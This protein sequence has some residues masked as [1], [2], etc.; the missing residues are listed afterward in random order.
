MERPEN[1]RVVILIDS[2]NYEEML[3]IDQPNVTL[4]NA[5]VNPNIDLIENGVQIADGAVRITSYYGHGYH[6]FSM[7]SNQKWN[8][9]V[10]N[11]NLENGTYS[12]NNAG[13]G[14][15]NGSFWNATVV[16][17]ANGFIAEGIIFENSF[18]QYISNKESQDV[19]VAWASGSPGVRPT[20]FGNVEV[21]NRI[22]VERAAAIAF[23]N[24]TD[25]AILNK[26]RVVGRQD[27]FFGGHGS[28]VVVY[29]GAVM[30][31]V[32]FIFGGMN[33]VFY[34][35]QLTMNTS[36]QS[37]DVSYDSLFQMVQSICLFHVSSDVVIPRQEH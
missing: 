11:V 14:T 17:R 26:C 5:A 24:N 19:V 6:Y 30:G 27:T 13:A 1:E 12:H 28:R 22:F 29:K 33:A 16:V 34:Q 25:K 10:L 9:E 35:T 21:Q 32:D 3:V 2:G 8:Q 4:K 7:G 31:A 18:N 37:N 23:P 20:S 15:T 36:D